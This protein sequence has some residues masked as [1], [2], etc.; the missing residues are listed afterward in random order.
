MSNTISYRGVI[1]LF[2]QE[3]SN[4]QDCVRYYRN[5]NSILNSLGYWGDI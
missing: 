3:S 1:S 5:L 2:V 4:F